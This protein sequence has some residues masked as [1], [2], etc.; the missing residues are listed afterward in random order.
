MSVLL[1]FLDTIYIISVVVIVGGADDH[2]MCN[3]YSIT[4]VVIGDLILET[5]HVHTS[6]I[7]II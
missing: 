5:D 1:I 6:H 3:S 7:S 4:R 2:V